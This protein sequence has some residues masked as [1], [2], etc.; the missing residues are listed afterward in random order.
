MIAASSVGRDHIGQWLV[1]RSIQVMS[2]SS[3][4]PARNDHSGCS[5]AYLLVVGRRVPGRDDRRGDVPAGVIRELVA[6]AQQGTGDRDRPLAELGQLGLGQAIEVLLGREVV[7]DERL[8]DVR[9]SPG[10]SGGFP[11]AVST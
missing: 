10:S 8:L 5:F 1:G 7:P 3:G 4:I 9:R 11:G 2:W 6:L